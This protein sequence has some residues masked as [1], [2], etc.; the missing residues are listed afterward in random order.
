M[1]VVSPEAW[2]AVSR[3]IDGAR[4]DIVEELRTLVRI[5]SVTGEEAA[6]GAHVLAICRELGFETVLSVDDGIRELVYALKSGLIRNP[7][8]EKYRNAQFI[9]Q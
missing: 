8:D 5:R 9:V 3:W 6:I 4:D 1:G 7:H 2:T